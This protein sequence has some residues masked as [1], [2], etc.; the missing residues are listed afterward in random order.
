MRGQTV[1]GGPIGGRPVPLVAVLGCCTVPATT[2]SGRSSL[3]HN[4]DA[5]PVVQEDCGH[6]TI[7]GRDLQGLE[8]LCSHNDCSIRRSERHIAVL[9]DELGHS[10]KVLTARIEKPEIPWGFCQVAKKASL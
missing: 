1:S 8:M 6:P 3:G 5:V 9:R 4:D 2:R 7:N 10:R